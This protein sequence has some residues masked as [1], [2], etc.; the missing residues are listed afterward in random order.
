M[1]NPYIARVYKNGEW[2][3][4]HKPSNKWIKFGSADFVFNKTRELNESIVYGKRE[5]IKD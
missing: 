4:F 3:V 5:S 1:I 2:G